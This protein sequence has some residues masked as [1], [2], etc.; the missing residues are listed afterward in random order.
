MG[1]CRKRDQSP[2]HRNSIRSTGPQL[3]RNFHVRTQR[4]S[5]V[6]CRSFTCSRTSSEL[7]KAPAKPTSKNAR[8][9]AP[10]KF[11][12]SFRSIGKKPLAVAS[13]RMTC[14]AGILIHRILLFSLQRQ[15]KIGGKIVDDSV[16]LVFRCRCPLADHLINDSSPTSFIEP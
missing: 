16:N 5:A 8:S 11:T 13:V 1:G 4:P 15:P 6:K 3:Y 14:R 12:R 7:R 10:S 9:G 2:S